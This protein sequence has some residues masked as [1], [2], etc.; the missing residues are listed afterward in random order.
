MN[1]F[2]LFANCIPVK[3]YN[4]SIICD[5]QRHTIDIIPNDL[6]IILTECE[7]MTVN[8]I[9]K[10]YKNEFNET[11]DEYFEFLIEKEFIF[12]TAH[13]ALFPKMNM[14]WDF[15]FEISNAIIDI[16]E[17]SPNILA[18]I[19]SL[20]TI[21][22]KNIQLRFFREVA[23]Q[24]II[25]IN[26]HLENIDS[27]VQHIEVI[28]P[29]NENN[30][31]EK[32]KEILSKFPRLKA[33]HIYNSPNNNFISLGNENIFFIFYSDKTITDCSSCG[34][35]DSTKF[36][37]NIELFSESIN[38]NS[39]LNKKIA[40]DIK[41]EIKNCPSMNTSFGNITNTSLQKVI[42]NQEFKK[43]GAI[44]KGSIEKCKD[45]E[46]R[47]ICIDCRAYLESPDNLYSKPLKCGYNPY[48]N[49][50]TDWSKETI[51]QFAI[52]HYKM[53]AN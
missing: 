4:Q 28:I 32:I 42:L 46:F 3:G 5:L 11:I 44:N 23:L 30:T 9:K 7:N 48:T 38:Y 21:N 41:G 20:E 25:K 15:P 33:F 36:V 14:Q 8:E 49:E 6:F 24:E 17:K 31:L 10:K 37:I 51:N 12:F 22:C 29:F 52:N 16:D 50:W 1:Y 43:I 39:C 40:I 27:I 13:P 2:V 45:C 47:Y 53:K 35:I 34:N 18:T 26:Q 19:D